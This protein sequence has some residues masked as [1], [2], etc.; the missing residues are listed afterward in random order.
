MKS[1]LI[2]TL[3]DE[4]D[5]H[6]QQ[7]WKSEGELWKKAG[8]YTH[9]AEL[10]NLRPGETHLDIGTGFGATIEALYDT[11][12]QATI[13][14]IDKS[15]TMILAAQ[16]ELKKSGVEA[17]VHAH[18][19][20]SEET[21]GYLKRRHFLNSSALSESSAA[22]HLICDDVRTAEVLKKILQE[23]RV[24]SATFLFPGAANTS[25]FEEPYRFDPDLPHGQMM[26]RMRDVILQVRKKAYAL[27][28]EH[29]KPQNKLVVADRAICPPGWSTGELVPFFDESTKTNLGQYASHWDITSTRLRFQPTGTPTGKWATEQGNLSAKDLPR[30]ARMVAFIQCLVRNAKE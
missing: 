13:L 20:L 26:E 6:Y 15:K 27:V 21:S 9:V 16:G 4:L 22:I 29:M 7:T 24:T 2:D 12:K 1:T 11:Q 17:Q 8:V 3:L 18:S 10:I 14:G 30:T 23:R 25:A 28:T 5:V 19:M